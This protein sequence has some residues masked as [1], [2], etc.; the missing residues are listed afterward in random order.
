[1]MAGEHR[2]RPLARSIG[3][4]FG[5]VWKGVRA[6]PKGPLPAGLE[7]KGGAQRRVV[8]RDVEEQTDETP[9]GRLTLRRTTIEEIEVSP[10]DER[11]DRSL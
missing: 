10:S 2:K 1:M 3:A 11:R 7:K 5:A 9:Q 4:F 8:R 6:D